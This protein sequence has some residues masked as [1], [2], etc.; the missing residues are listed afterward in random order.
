MIERVVVNPEGMI[1][2]L[3]LLAPFSYLYHVTQ[4]IQQ[5]N[6]SVIE[7]NANANPE[8][9]ECSDYVQSGEPSFDVPI[10]RPALLFS[11]FERSC[12]PDCGTQGD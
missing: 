8:V 3:E 2:R 5:R 11:F 4:R 6:G 7:G 12:L 1:T 9:G 10:L